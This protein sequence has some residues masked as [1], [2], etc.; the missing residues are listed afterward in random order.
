MSQLN[1]LNIVQRPRR[2]RKSAAIRNLVQ[3]HTLSVNDL[4]YPLFVCPGT[5]VV[6]EVSSMPGSFRYSIDNAVKECQ[7]LWDLGIQ[8]IDLFGIPERKTEDGSEA[9][10]ENGIIQEALRAIKAKVPDLC[11]M[12]DVAL[13]PFTPF[14]HDGLVENGIILNDETVEVLCKMAISHANAGADFVSPS[15]MMDGR[16][17]AI[18]EALDDTGFSDVGILSYA[19]KYASSFYGPF[20]DALHSAPQFGDKSTYQMNPGNTDEAM[21]EIELDIIEGADIVMV[22]PGLAYL[23]IVRRAKERF[24]IPVAIYHVSG[25]YSM[26]KAAAARGWIDE[27]RVMMESLLCMKRAGGDLIFTYYAKEAAK[28]LR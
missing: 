14:G 22:K 20:R 17:G 19:A 5:N 10:N 26:V 23:D 24:D 12:T 25:E 8:S 21:K 3:E 4:V 27:K 9:F 2:L 16:I 1:L 11:I 6:E 7:E 13:D 15:D 18:R 28:L